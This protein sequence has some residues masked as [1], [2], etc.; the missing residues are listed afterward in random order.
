MKTRWISVAVL[1]LTTA[2]VSTSTSCKLKGRHT[3]S[4]SESAETDDDS[5]DGDSSKSSDSKKKKSKKGGDAALAASDAPSSSAASN[6]TKDDDG[7]KKVRAAGEGKP[8]NPDLGDFKLTV[9][10]T[11]NPKFRVYQDMAEK[12]KGLRTVVDTMNHS[13]NLPRDIPVNV[14][15]CQVANAWYSPKT[16]DVSVCYEFYELLDKAI[17]KMYAHNRTLETAKGDLD[18]TVAFF[19]THEFGHAL[20]GELNLGVVGGEED[21]VDDLAGAI[22]ILDKREDVMLDAIDAFQG[23]SKLTAGSKP[24][25]FDE[26]SFT[27]QRAYNTTCLVYGSN[28]KRWKVLVDKGFL[29]PA[30]AVRCPSEFERKIKGWGAMLAGHVKSKAK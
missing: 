21:A 13:I 12:S 17:S 1:A 10:P 16:H 29:P 30:R 26:H 2:L 3:D 11:K 18:N 9:F 22:L 24:A 23:L 4:A 28:P 15:D 25:Y 7:A 27:E 14:K 8:Q 20:I 6:S 5:S 19:A